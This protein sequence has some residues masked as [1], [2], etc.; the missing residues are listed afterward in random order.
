M[1]YTIVL[2]TGDEKNAGT[3][4]QVFIRI[5]GENSKMHTGRIGLQLAKKKK[6][7][8]GSSETFTIEALD[9]GEIAQVEVNWLIMVIKGCFNTYFLYR[10][11]MM[12]FH[13]EVAGF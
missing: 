11:D 9:V 13:Q 3:L 5:I 6:F 10:S 4:A 2:K 8:P 12:E 7:E 1:L